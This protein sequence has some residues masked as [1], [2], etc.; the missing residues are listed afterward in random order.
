[1]I[2]SIQK[3]ASEIIK[4]SKSDNEKINELLIYRNEMKQIVKDKQV[5]YTLP[6]V[7]EVLILYINYIKEDSNL[8]KEEDLSKFFDEI[9]AKE[10]DQVIK[11]DL[12]LNWKL[13][14]IDWK[15]NT[16]NIQLFAPQKNNTG[17]EVIPIIKFDK[18]DEW[19]KDIKDHVDQNK[20][21]GVRVMSTEDIIFIFSS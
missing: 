13:W 20:F 4:S 3:K 10:T 7:P 6:L 19:V 1:M 2:N 21:R 11:K 8:E 15:T 16:N 5:D 18:N 17:F 14:M 12:Q 9:I